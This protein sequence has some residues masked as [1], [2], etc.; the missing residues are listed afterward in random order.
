MNP[1]LLASKEALRCFLNDQPYRLP[2][3]PGLEEVHRNGLSGCLAYQV[4]RHGHPD[5][6]FALAMKD[7]YKSSFFKWAR[8]QALL[9]ELE[10]PL[11]RAGL[12]V[13]L[14]KGSALARTVYPSPGIRPLS[15][16]DMLVRPD[17]RGE[18]GRLLSAAGMVESSDG[19]MF[20]DRQGRQID[21]HGPDVGR[22]ERYCGLSGEE[23]WAD[24]RPLEGSRVWRGLGP[25]TAL[26][27]LAVHA[28]KHSYSRMIW[29]VDIAL[30][31][32][33]PDLPPPENAA[34]RSALEDGLYL[35][36][37]LSGEPVRSK[38][39]FVLR[40][41]LTSMPGRDQHPLGQLLLAWHQ[42]GW[43]DRSRFMRTA[44][45]PPPYDD[46]ESR[47]QRYWRL[48]R[49]ASRIVRG[50]IFQGIQ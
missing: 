33:Q 46:L 34:A 42:P 30:V 5:A 3:P 12:E 31:A 26:A 21:V 1:G 19:L 50:T 20:S 9:E 37:R 29:L 24:C 28:L 45:S 39:N 48:L 16:V 4:Q 14:L 23:A 40:L 22:A 2:P 18:L 49:Q 32:R 36:A 44:F 38:P 13:I 6:D 43:A 8:Y 35:A 47:T 10:G 27:H 25:R 17:Q 15:D 41:L 7:L 11:E